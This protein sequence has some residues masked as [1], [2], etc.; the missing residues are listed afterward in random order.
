MDRTLQYYEVNKERFA[1]DTAEADMGEIR[2][3]FLSLLPREARILDFGCGTGRDA[4][5]FKDK[6]HPVVAMDASA[7]MC[8]LASGRLGQ[9][10]LQ[11][12]FQELREKEAYQGVWACAS[13][14]HLPRTELTEVL[15]RVRDALADQGILYMSF[16]YG[17][18]EGIRDGRY[19]LDLKE[20][21]LDEV[22]GETGG[23]TLQR[24][25]TSTDVRPGRERE[26]WL[27][28]LAKKE[29]KEMDLC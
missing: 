26:F 21:A 20:S 7:G 11:K 5:F 9:P 12:R 10:V 16:K 8:A 13:L 15:A 24:V 22:L 28:V 29:K 14:L 2:E 18:F 1:Q 4:R 3:A 27:N 17:E 25:W 23:L 19:F 6:G